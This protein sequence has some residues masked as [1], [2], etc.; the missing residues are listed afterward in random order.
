MKAPPSRS[1]LPR[2]HPRPA[3]LAVYRTVLRLYPKAFRDRWADETV[4]LFAELAR[5]HPS[6]LTLW[7]THVP[8]LAGGLLAEWWRECA[9]RPRRPLRHG[10]LAGALLSGATLAGNLGRLWATPANR[11]VSW[12]VTAVALAVLVMPARPA[13]TAFGT[14]RRALRDGCVSGLI[15]FSMANLTAGVIVLTC[16]D[17]LREDPIQLAAFTASHERNFRIYQLHEL[18]GGWV[19]GSLAGALL[20]AVGAAVT[21]AASWRPGRHRQDAG[22]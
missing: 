11:L 14:V 3:S 4:L 22:S 12:L 21:A 15:A 19:Y 6:G 5:R 10:V 7:V 17:R 2:N 1:F 8:D 18:L 13:P 16:L 9:V 20:G